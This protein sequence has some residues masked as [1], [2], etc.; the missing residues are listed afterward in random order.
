[1]REYLTRTKYW[2]IFEPMNPTIG[3]FDGDSKIEVFMNDNGREHFLERVLNGFF[4]FLGLTQ[5]DDWRTYRRGP[6][7]D[8]KE[9]VYGIKD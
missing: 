6:W 8:R 4:K 1:M 7:L 9:V 2:D 3:M 5:N